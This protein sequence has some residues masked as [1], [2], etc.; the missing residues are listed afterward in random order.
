MKQRAGTSSA[1]YPGRRTTP[2]RCGAAL[3]AL[4]AALAL[5]G[6]GAG[7]QDGSVGSGEVRADRNGIIAVPDGKRAKAPR[8][9]GATVA[10]GALDE[11]AYR[12]K[13]VV[14]NLWS[15]TCGPCRAE[16]PA[17]AKVAAQT[18]ARGVAFL[19]INTRDARRDSA[20]AFETS[21]GV[22]Y[23]SLYDPDG[24]V[25]LSFPP[26]TFVQAVPATVVLDRHGRVAARAL[27]PLG[28]SAL[29]AMLA[30]VLAEG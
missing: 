12:G 20:R 22:G 17:F 24:K 23:P 28:V 9:H 27:A 30:P 3:L 10:G 5:T 11:A 7:G 14:L 18:Q 25:M 26:G 6:C 21:H 8:L 29:R 15:S 13:V 2:T 16:A 1:A 4:A 19:G